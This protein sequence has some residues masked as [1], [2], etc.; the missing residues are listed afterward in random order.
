MTRAQAI[1]SNTTRDSDTELIDDLRRKLA[2]TA[3]DRDNLLHNLARITAAL[4]MPE[5]MEIDKVVRR[6]EELA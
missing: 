2:A 3:A 1:A 5:G 6:I 4:G